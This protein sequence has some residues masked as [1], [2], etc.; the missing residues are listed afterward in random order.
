MAATPSLLRPVSLPPDMPICRH[1]RRQ[2]CPRAAD[3]H[4]LLASVM[5]A[6][7]FV[8]AEKQPVIPPDSNFDGKVGIYIGSL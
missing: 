2:G 3:L 8:K 7:N 1:H 6:W 4:L 5:V